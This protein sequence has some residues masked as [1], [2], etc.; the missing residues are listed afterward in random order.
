M[1]GVVGTCREDETSQPPYSNSTSSYSRRD[2][3]ANPDAQALVP[4]SSSNFTTLIDPLRAAAPSRLMA[5][6]FAPW[7]SN[8]LT[9]SADPSMQQFRCLI[10]DILQ[11]LV[12]SDIRG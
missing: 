11:I 9:A 6:N 8:A 7:S 4:V 2:S 10:L 5:G 1:A 12:E 3:V